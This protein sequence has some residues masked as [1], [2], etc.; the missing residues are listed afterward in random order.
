MRRSHPLRFAIVIALVLTSLAPI[1]SA[2][3]RLLEAQPGPNGHVD[4]PPAEVVIRFTERV[5]REYT[6]AEV[7]D[8]NGTRVDLREVKFEGSDQIRVPLG[9]L[10]DDVYTVK[11]YSLSVDTHTF[12]G[13][14]LFAVGSASLVGVAPP[15]AAHHHGEGA[16]PVWLES[17]ARALHYASA[18]AAIGMPAFVLFIARAANAA[19]LRRL[20]GTLLGITALGALGAATVLFAFSQRVE[21]PIGTVASSPLGSVGSLLTLRAGLQILIFTTALVLVATHRKPA[22]V[23]PL[24]AVLLALGIFT[25]WFTSQSSHAAALSEGRITA[26]G[27]DFLHLIAGSVW[28]GGVFA[29]LF[30]FWQE[31][32][33]TLA[34]WIRRFSP[35][36]MT[37]VLFIILTGTFASVLHLTHPL[38]L[39]A[40]A[41]GG[42][43]LLK[44]LLLVP[45]IALGAFNRYIA[46]RRLTEGTEWR[47]SNLH[48][49]LMVET[50]LMACVL[51]A[52]GVLATSAPPSTEMDYPDAPTV[53]TFEESLGKAHLILTIAPGPLKVGLHNYTVELHALDGSNPEGSEVFL[54]FSPPGRAK[55]PE[56][57]T[58]KRVTSDRWTLDGGFLTERGE[59]TIHVTTQADDYDV[60]PFNVT[61]E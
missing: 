10:T 27:A 42:M 54:E 17:L 9:N 20:F 31:S 56:I 59:W 49:A 15:S 50:S 16:L 3:A 30:L 29:F 51:I 40:G 24:L 13:A 5:Q 25:T 57:H 55:L 46:K 8:P 53:V 23:R 21:T 32:R 4:A 52:A 44:V 41:Y 28:I 43:I 1:A 60:T 7:Y 58:M 35:L 33:D 6:R 47:S 22:L 26:I 14:Y 12:E 37:C 61:V 18:A 2:H 19:N 11:W 39:F 48:R 36:A 34:L 38:D 45:L